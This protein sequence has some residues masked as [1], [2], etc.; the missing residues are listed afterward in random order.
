MEN[1]SFDVSQVMAIPGISI[2]DRA[3]ALTATFVHTFTKPYCHIKLTKEVDLSTTPFRKMGKNFSNC[4]WE[5]FS[6]APKEFMTFG[7][8]MMVMHHTKE[9][10]GSYKHHVIIASPSVTAHDKVTFIVIAPLED[11]EIY[12]AENDHF[13]FV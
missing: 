5:D 10:G 1:V 8:D 9:S 12:E 3:N 11:I 13:S 6:V 7:N 4:F 2:D